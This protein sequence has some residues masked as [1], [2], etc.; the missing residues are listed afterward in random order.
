MIGFVLSA[1][2]LGDQSA[3]AGETLLFA[4][5]PGAGFFVN[6]AYVADGGR[7][8]LFGD[9][10]VVGVPAPASLALFGLGLLGLA[11][12]RRRGAG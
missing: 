8:I 1:G 9:D 4:L 2:Y 3:R 10:T 6:P 12:L 7:V 11:T 5:R